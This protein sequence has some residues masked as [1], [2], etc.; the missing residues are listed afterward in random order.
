MY[1]FFFF[2]Y[3]CFRIVFVF[4]IGCYREPLCVCVYFFGEAFEQEP[5][6]TNWLVLLL[7][8]ICEVNGVDEPG[9]I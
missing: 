3:L 5:T 2:H 1:R 9:L 6:V 4:C 7:W 8:G